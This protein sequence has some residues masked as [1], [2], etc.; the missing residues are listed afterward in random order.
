MK[1]S[2]V[3]STSPVLAQCVHKARAEETVDAER[4]ERSAQLARQP[5]GHEVQNLHDGVEGVAEVDDDESPLL[6]STRKLE[7]WR[8]SMPST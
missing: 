1:M 2:R 6:R 3:L 4:L 8:S 5:E 7:R